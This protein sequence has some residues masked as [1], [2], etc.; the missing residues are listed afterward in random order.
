MKKSTGVLVLVAV[1]VAAVAALV[2]CGGGASKV[3]L[4]AYSTPREAFAELTPAFRKTDADAFFIISES[5][6]RGASP[7][8][9]GPTGKTFI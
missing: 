8:Q 4:V 3:A 5:L 7:S 2:A 6:L 1:T 9:T